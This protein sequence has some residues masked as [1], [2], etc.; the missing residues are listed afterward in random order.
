MFQSL[1]LLP[2]KNGSLL[3]NDKSNFIHIA[4]YQ[5][6]VDKLGQDLRPCFAIEKFT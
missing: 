1:Y 4:E 5:S 6:F 2:V 3:K